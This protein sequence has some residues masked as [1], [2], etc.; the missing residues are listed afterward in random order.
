MSASVRP[1]PTACTDAELLGHLLDGCAGPA[2]RRLPRPSDGLAELLVRDGLAPSAA[3]RL[4]CAVEL[5][6][7]CLRPPG[8][9]APRLLDPEG[10]AAELRATAAALTV[11]AFWAFALD[12]QG[13]LL[14]RH[15]VSRGTLTSSLVHPREVFVPALLHRAAS[16]V[17]AHNHPSGDPEPSADD[18]AT[19]RRLERA[20]RLLGVPLLD[21]VVL[22]AGSHVSFRERGWIRP[23]RS[24]SLEKIH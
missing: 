9:A 8:H 17:V 16:V 13:V 3:L 7:R 18:R 24:E 2:P 14:H 23:S 4:G 15:E 22:G 6:R 21:H 1:D 20:G 10:V 11:E 5:A 19:T 12:A